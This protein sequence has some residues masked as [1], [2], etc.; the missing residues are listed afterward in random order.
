MNDRRGFIGSSEISIVM[1]LNPFKSPLQLWAEKTGKVEPD[2]LSTNEAVEWG[3][4]LEEVVAAKFAEKHGV[5]LI[6]YKKRFVHPTYKFLTCELDRLI[7]GTDEIVEVKTMNAWKYKD[8]S[9]D[10]GVPEHIICQVIFALGLSKRKKAHVA[11]LIGGNR[12]FEREVIFDQDL[13]DLMVKQAVVFW[14]MV[15]HDIPPMAEGMDNPFMVE[16]YP[17]NDEQM[18]QINELNDKVG[19]LQQVKGNID[20]MEAEKD[21]L[22]AEIKAVIGASMGFK[23]VEYAVT[24]KSQQRTDIDREKLKSDG[25]YEKYVTKSQARYLRVKKTQG[26]SNGNSRINQTAVAEK[27]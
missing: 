11:I 1:G 23:T 2:D 24:W 4:R 27:R 12:Y 17:T 18:Q 7:A 20:A 13:F 14:E 22:E 9:Q 19:Y 8:I 5:K 15:E 3:T 10:E 16:L 26:E 25:L 6:A 21:K